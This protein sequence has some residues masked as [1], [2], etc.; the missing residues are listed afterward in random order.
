MGMG[1]DDGY[2]LLCSTVRSNIRTVLCMRARI[3][4]RARVRMR[5][6]SRKASATS[7]GTGDRSSPIR[8]VSVDEL[9]EKESR[10]GTGDRQVTEYGAIERNTRYTAG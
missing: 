8:A 10:N 9:R 4:T 2:S 5:V 3:Q 1:M 7:A 6:N